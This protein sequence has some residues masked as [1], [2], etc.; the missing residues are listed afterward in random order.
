MIR[1]LS[2]TIMGSEE[3]LYEL[4]DNVKEF[5]YKP[6]LSKCVYEGHGNLHVIVDEDSPGVTYLKDIS[7][8]LNLYPHIAQWVEYTQ[9]EIENSKFYVMRIPEPLELAGTDSSDYGTQYA[10][11]CAVCGIDRKPISDIMVDRKFIK[12]YQIGTLY[13][14]IFIS[15]SVRNIINVNNL[16]GF[17]IDREV[18]DF[19]GREMPKYYHL[20]VTNVLP[21][22][23]QATWL[24]RGES[25]LYLKCEHNIIYLRSD[26]RYNKTELENALDFNLTYE[27]LDNYRMRNLIVSSKT[28]KIFRQSKIYAA[29]TP[30]T[31]DE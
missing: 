17:L 11:G 7:E 10:G 6:L 2:I 25:N 20:E 12:K 28:R 3:I 14:E 5:I 27:Y 4:Y 1:K 29:F 21:P 16:S 30:I 15:E 24:Y 19:K 26:H 23:N 8:S 22:M 13:P 18:K 31:I 9:E